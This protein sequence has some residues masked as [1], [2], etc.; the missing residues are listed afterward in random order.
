MTI[1][2]HITAS[3]IHWRFQPIAKIYVFVI[4]DHHRFQQGRVKQSEDVDGC[5]VMRQMPSSW[6]FV[7]PEDSSS[8]LEAQDSKDSK[9]PI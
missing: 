1:G 2:I 9:W 3:I 6:W 5:C 4:G 7:E 8:T